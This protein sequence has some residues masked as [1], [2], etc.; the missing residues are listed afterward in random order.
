MLKSQKN[1]QTKKQIRNVTFILLI[2]SL[3]ILPN[4]GANRR[5]TLSSL[6]VHNLNTGEDFATI[7]EA[8][9]DED[10]LEGHTILADA[11]TY[12]EYVVIYKDNLTIFGENPAT[13]IID[14]GGTGDVVFIAASNI[15]VMNF[16]I[17]N[18]GEDGIHINSYS[19]NITILNNNIINNFAY[20]IYL[21]TSSRCL[22]AE[23]NITLNYGAIL[24]SYSS[25]NT[26]FHN[27]IIN[28]T[29]A[30]WL[31]YSDN[32]TIFHNNFINNTYQVDSWESDN[33]W[34]D[35]Y[36]SGGNYW[37][38]YTGQD[39]DGDGIGDTP[40]QIDENDNDNY[41]LMNPYI[42]GDL[43]HDGKVSVQDMFIL[44]KA[45]GTTPESPQWN[46]AADINH[47]N[48]VDTRDLKRLHKNYGKTSLT[49]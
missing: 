12:N 41:P 48:I 42:D 22:I 2:L 18:G 29:Y 23:N 27:N 37:D 6:P 21:V 11:W 17:Q 39:S 49:Q 31:D 40:Y 4:L 45:F 10:T 9:D 38:D 16:T 24:L 30:L 8:I 46:P 35:E 44:G 20:G 19:N 32:N 26:I 47:D 43:N 13:T 1:E 7:Q 15:R 3:Y 33:L 34:N 25:N 36:P 5:A 28:H 14:S